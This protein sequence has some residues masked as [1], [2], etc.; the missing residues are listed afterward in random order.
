MILPDRH[1]AEAGEDWREA[2][3]LGFDSAWTYDHMSWRPLEDHPWFSPYPVL[4][5]AACSTQRIKLG[6]LV[7][8]PNFRHPVTTVKDAISVD[9]ISKGRFVLGVGAGS[10]T[11]GDDRVIDPTP[12]SPRNRAERFAEFVEL[13]GLMLRQTPVT[14]EGRF[15]SAFESRNVAS[16]AR[17]RPLPIAVAATGP[18]GL[19]LAARHGSAW[20]TFGA[21]VHSKKCTPRETLDMV[22]GQLAG[23]HR[24]CER[25]GRDPAELDKIFVVTDFPQQ[26]RSPSAFVDYARSY[27]AIGITDL[28]IHR[29]R[30]T[31]IYQADPQML[32]LIAEKA[33][34]EIHDM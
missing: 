27:A 4:T 22:S 5:A 17:R 2:E 8:S 19:E 18:R 11:A 6:T 21:P 32:H 1:W 7:T 13:T 31:G 34:S 25:I 16:A 15:F 30:P 23:L 12:L 26:S 33:L 14:Y 28:V 24:A 10:T 20:V 9:D 3:E 29:P